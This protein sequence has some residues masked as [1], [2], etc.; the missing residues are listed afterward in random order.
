MPQTL[1]HQVCTSYWH[2]VLQ[3]CVYDYGCLS[4]CYSVNGTVITKYGAVAK[5]TF[6]M[7]GAL[8]LLILLSSVTATSTTALA[9][10]FDTQYA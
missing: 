2:T 1:C 6:N 9:P 4:C 10:E 5:Y 3:E 7:G 8:F